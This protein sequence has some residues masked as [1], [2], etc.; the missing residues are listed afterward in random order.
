MSSGRCDSPSWDRLTGAAHPAANSGANPN[1]ANNMAPCQGIR[2][3]QEL[4]MDNSQ[5]RDG[6]VDSSEI[7]NSYLLTAG[8]AVVRAVFSYFITAA[9]LYRNK[10]GGILRI[11]QNCPHQPGQPPRAGFLQITMR[12]AAKLAQKFWFFWIIRR[13]DDGAKT[14][15]VRAL[16]PPQRAQR[17]VKSVVDHRTKRSSA[18]APRF[19]GRAR[20]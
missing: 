20:F 2:W 15:L 7:S 19:A 14:F 4:D 13:N 1:T 16:S 8:A 6:R 11:N 9:D 3:V 10:F 12:T 18:S 17:E 5:I